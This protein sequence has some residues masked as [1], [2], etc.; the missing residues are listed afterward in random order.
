MTSALRPGGSTTRWRRLRTVVLVRDKGVCWLCN[1][2]ADQVDHVV[3]RV[4]GGTDGL[5]NLKAICR[6]CNLAKGSKIIRGTRQTQPTTS[7]LW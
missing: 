2:K 3:P 5:N 7:R 6:P 1:G 4:H